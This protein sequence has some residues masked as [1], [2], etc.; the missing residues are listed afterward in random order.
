MAAS[1]RECVKTLMTSSSWV[2]DVLWLSDSTVNAPCR[3]RRD[4]EHVALF[5]QHLGWAEI[6]LFYADSAIIKPLAPMIFMTRFRL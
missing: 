6:S 2:I 4:L 3:I 1:G 5:L